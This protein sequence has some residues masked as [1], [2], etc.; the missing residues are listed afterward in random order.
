MLIISTHIL[1][2]VHGPDST[3]RGSLDQTLHIICRVQFK[4]T[5][6]L[7]HAD[8]VAVIWQSHELQRWARAVRCLGAVAGYWSTL[9]G[10]E[11]LLP[12]H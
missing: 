7:G 11:R 2:Y 8:V 9:H 5:A 3:Y 6:V 1:I 12:L 4:F 10:W